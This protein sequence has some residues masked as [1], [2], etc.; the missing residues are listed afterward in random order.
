MPQGI[1]DLTT[2]LNTLQSAQG[3]F[4]TKMTDV[5]KKVDDL[6]KAVGEAGPTGLVGELKSVSK[7]LEGLSTKNDLDNWSQAKAQAEAK[8]MEAAISRSVKEAM[9][10][11]QK[12]TVIE[13][14][15]ELARCEATGK[16]N[17][18]AFSELKKETLDLQT[19]YE[20]R[21]KR[22][23]TLQAENYRLNSSLQ[24]QN[25]DLAS[26][27]GRLEE[28]TKNLAEAE[29]RLGR[30]DESIRQAEQD[31]DSYIKAIE[32]KDVKMAEMNIRLEAAEARPTPPMTV[33]AGTEMSE[34]ARAY[35]LMSN[36]VR[37]IPTV[38]ETGDAFDM[39][40]VA[41][42]IMP[43]LMRIDAKPRVLAFLDA[44][45]QGWH[46]LEDVVTRGARAPSMP[47]GRCLT[48]RRECVLT[49]VRVIGQRAVLDFNN[50]FN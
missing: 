36:E 22:L 17:E 31:L 3:S 13:Q 11:F 10:N 30:K 47:L 25:N 15:R 43:L 19:R 9:E 35:L 37:D 20:E 2:K 42:E 44:R 38:P 1:N 12:S 27:S 33:Q 4:G 40:Q 14:S 24:S 16:K 34:L 45:P 49:R 21:G 18:A 26:N 46:C 39:Q 50:I 8:T 7:V 23:E 28:L 5:V 48:H 6:A 41:I 32:S 29:K